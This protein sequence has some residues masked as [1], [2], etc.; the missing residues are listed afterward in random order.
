MAT[1]TWPGNFGLM[2]SSYDRE[3]G[4]VETFRYRDDDRHR[5]HRL[6]FA[7]SGCVSA[8]GR[9]YRAGAACAVGEPGEP[10]GPHYVYRQHPALHAARFFR[11]RRLGSPGWRRRKDGADHAPRG[12]F[13]LE[14]GIASIF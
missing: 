2:G 8:G 7:L 14:H 13:K 10:T 1:I 5:D 4:A 9:W 12:A 3:I 11:D 6:R